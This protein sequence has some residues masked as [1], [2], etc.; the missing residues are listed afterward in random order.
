MTISD[1]IR[2]LLIESYL[3]GESSHKRFPYLFCRRGGF[4]CFNEMQKGQIFGLNTLCSCY[5][6]IKNKK[7]L[8]MLCHDERTRCKICNS[9]GNIFGIHR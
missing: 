3:K 4:Q 2:K 9:D 6:W 5:A 7:H 8:C 1:E